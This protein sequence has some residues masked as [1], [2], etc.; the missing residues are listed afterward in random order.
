MQCPKD[1]E[2]G[3]SP[4]PACVVEVG[5]DLATTAQVR[6]FGTGV[7][8]ENH[9][10]P[11]FS[12]FSPKQAGASSSALICTA[13]SLAVQGADIFLHKLARCAIAGP[14]RNPMAGLGWSTAF[15][16]SGFAQKTDAEPVGGRGISAFPSLFYFLANLF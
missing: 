16:A 6:T 10:L 7:D 8:L 11:R 2:Y 14:L 13:L 1:A 4:R 5:T 12:N 9:H 3:Y 15:I